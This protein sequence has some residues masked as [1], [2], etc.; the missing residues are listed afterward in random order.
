MMTEYLIIFV[1][2]PSVEVSRKIG[3]MLVENKLAACVNIISK[4][5]SIFFWKGEVCESEEYLLICKSKASLFESK[6]IPA[7][8]SNHPYE[9]PEIVA[10][11]LFGGNPAYK[12]WINE[13]LSK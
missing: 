12:N 10:I 7:V 13:V 6:F 2:V 5:Q 8:E 3:S 9:V 1:T 4:V 11:P